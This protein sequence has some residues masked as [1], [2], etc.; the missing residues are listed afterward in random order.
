MSYCRTEGKDKII[1]IDEE[2]PPVKES[3]RGEATDKDES[4]TEALKAT[5]APKEAPA[6]PVE[7]STSETSNVATD[8]LRSD[9]EFNIADEEDGFIREDGSIDW[10]CPVCPAMQYFIASPCADSFK[11]SFQCFHDTQIGKKEIEN[12]FEEMKAFSDCTTSNP[13]FFGSFD[14]ETAEAEVEGEAAATHTEE[15]TT[16]TPHTLEVTEAPADGTLA[17]TETPSE[18]S[19]TV[20]ADALELETETTSLTDKMEELK[21]EDEQ[22]DASLEEAS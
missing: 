18:I 5:I 15:P 1:F 13:E 11:E 21:I 6:T 9:E 3:D 22:T 2:A 10:N 20:F 4:T 14:E 19:N 17:A 7:T 12:C 16:K 8:E